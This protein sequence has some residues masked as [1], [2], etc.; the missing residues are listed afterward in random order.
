MIILQKT[1]K[2]SLLKKL[3]ALAV[4][5]VSVFSMMSESVF[6]VAKAFETKHTEYELE[7]WGYDFRNSGLPNKYNHI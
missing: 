4:T 2:K 1:K 3:T 6:T 7:Y 5:F